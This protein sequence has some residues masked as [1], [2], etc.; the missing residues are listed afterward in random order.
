MTTLA[1]SL[2]GAAALL[3]AFLSAAPAQAQL[4]HTFVSAAGGNDVN[5]CSHD[6]P[7]RTLQRAHDRTD[8]AGE[9]TI[10]DPGHYG[11]VVITKSLNIVNDGGGEAGIL[12]SGGDAGI[13]IDAPA[14]ASVSLRGLAI[15]GIGFGGG[16]GVVFNSGLTLTIAN[17]LIRDHSADGIEFMPRGSG[18]LAI[19]NTL[20]ADNAGFGIIVQP[21]GAGAVKAELDRVQIHNN[22]SVGLFINGEDSTGTIDAV[23]RESVAANNGF[24]LFVSSNA[25]HAATSLTMYRSVSANSRGNGIVA[26]GPTA[27]LQI[28]ASI[29]TGNLTSWAVRDG[30][31][32]HSFAENS[33]AGNADGD[34]QPPTMARK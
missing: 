24:G 3:A 27:T 6:M 19:A 16:T 5:D 23:M 30:A 9:V 11:A 21:S 28:G 26:T 33:I 17:C 32:L 31:V 13:T 20:V 25:E 1:W 29:V 7:C 22:T 14:T 8:D 4:T 15:E 2:A 34:P 12:V 18:T 10:L